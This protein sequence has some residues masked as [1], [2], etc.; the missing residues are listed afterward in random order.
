MALYKDKDG[1]YFFV[2]DDPHQ[3][4]GT[5]EMRIEGRWV[6]TEWSEAYQNS[7]EKIDTCIDSLFEDD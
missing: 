2:H 4:D 7:C 1:V 6:T 3:Y 5:A